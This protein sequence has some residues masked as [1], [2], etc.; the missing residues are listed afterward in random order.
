[1]KAAKFA[2]TLSIFVDVAQAQSFS[3][4]AR[5]GGL[6]VSS[7]ARQIDALESELQVP[8]FVRSTRALVPTEAGEVLYERAVKILHDM[9]EAR[10][11]VISLEQNVQGL[12]RVSCLP[13]FAR[14]Y[15]VPILGRLGERHPQLQVELALTERIVDPVVERM[16]VVVRVGQQPDSSLIGQ[17]IGSHRYLMCAAPSYLERYGTPRRLS[18]LAR[19][20]LIDRRHS[21]SVRGWREIG[22]GAWARQAR[23]VLECDDCD[24]RR[25]AALDGLGIALMPNWSAGPEIGRGNLV[26]IGL[27]DC[28]PPQDSG[29][30]LLRA[31]P[32]ASAR[33]RAFTEALRRHIGSPSIWDV[34]IDAAAA[35][36][37]P[38][39]A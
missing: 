19:H 5:R 31:M 35:T 7:V 25:Q 24:A 18:E 29:I 2:E 27:Q 8:L 38:S 16:D 3:E 39:A 12:L 10:S 28:T 34:T 4:V 20:R 15:V 1:M 21:T 11:E 23:F 37:P 14:R 32:R 9:T 6:V 13:A 22:D 33:I 17:R 26:Q 36:T 30:Y